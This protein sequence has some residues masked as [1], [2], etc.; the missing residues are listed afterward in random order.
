MSN[1]PIDIYTD[2]SSRENVAV[3]GYSVYEDGR[4]IHEET[5]TISPA[6][7]AVAEASAVLYSMTQYQDRTM[8]IY[9]DSEYVV[10]A[11]TG[12]YNIKKNKELWAI[13]K[14]AYVECDVQIIHVKGHDINERNN[15]IDKLVRKKLKEYLVERG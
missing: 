13:L 4:L 1:K 9:S 11:I 2:A 12:I 3:I 10:K 15:R 14:K 8:T 5:R 6:T 7:S